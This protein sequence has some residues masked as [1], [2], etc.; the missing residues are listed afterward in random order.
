MESRW[1]DNKAIT[2]DNNVIPA[3]TKITVKEN[4]TV[5]DKVKDKD[6]YR[7]FAH[8]KL[9]FKDLDKLKEKYN[10]VRFY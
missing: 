3:I 10:I 7:R 9:S 1:K 6:I 2:K 4:V 5:K 8:L